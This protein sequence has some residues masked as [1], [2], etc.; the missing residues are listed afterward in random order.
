[1]AYSGLVQT[2]RYFTLYLVSS[3]VIDLLGLLF[4][5]GTRGYA[6]FFMVSTSLLA[7]LL[8][9]AV[10]ELYNRIIQR[11]AG[12]GY[13]GGG[14]LAGAAAVGILISAG[15]ALVDAKALPA[16]GLL[17]VAV[18]CQ[19][20]LLSV[21]VVVLVIASRFF[22]RYRSVMIRN[23]VVHSR[24]LTLYCAITAVAYFSTNLRADPRV[25][26]ALFLSGYFLCQ[27]LWFALL[28]KAGEYSTA[29]PSTPER[30]E[31]ARQSRQQL[32]KFI[33]DL[34][35]SDGDNEGGSPKPE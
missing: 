4:D 23:L 1:M 16:T 21:A 32:E 35:R 8:L 14:V 27:C 20:W 19:R 24:V 11:F 2:Y 7:V 30:I 17:G 22:F 34:E 5:R 12:L 29:P 10:F 25:V 15:I 9:A 31:E 26:S 3:V 28:S 33:D 18:F 6:L 13:L